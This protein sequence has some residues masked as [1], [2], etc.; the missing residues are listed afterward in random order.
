MNATVKKN[1]LK[2]RDELLME[3]DGNNKQISSSERDVGDFYDDV[4]VEKYRQMIN[5]LGER[6]RAKLKAINE[7]LRKIEDGIYGECEECGENIN[8]KRLN[9]LPFARYCVK[10]QSEF[11]KQLK[12]HPDESIE[13][14]LL[15]KDVSIS[16]MENS[17]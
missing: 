2:I 8:K 4:D 5:T 9:V 11:E 12:P 7:A 16:D 6:D 17:D 15:Y 3:I 13:D 10:C 14:K 1:L